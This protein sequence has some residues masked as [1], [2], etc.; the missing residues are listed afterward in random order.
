MWKS[1]L[2]SWADDAIALLFPYLCACCADALKKGETAICLACLAELPPTYDL[3]QPSDNP[4]AQLFWGRIPYIGVASAY[5]FTSPGHVQELV[6]ALKYNGRKD[7]GLA[8]GRRFGHQLLTVFPF[9]TID[10]VVPVPLHARR[11]RERGYNQAAC[12]GKGIA[13]AIGVPLLTGA[14]VRQTATRTQTRKSR[15]ARWEN[16]AEVFR[17]VQPEQLIGK[18]LLLVDDVIT[19]GATL[20]AA[21]QPLLQLSNTKLSL[22]SIAA[23]RQ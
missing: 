22:A 2:R 13:D 3:D 20:E 19:T 23:T 8:L 10:A 5:I 7:V 17:V 6:H 12:F 21:A 11:E 18:H 1:H 4:T 9:K 16:V 15:M 14:L